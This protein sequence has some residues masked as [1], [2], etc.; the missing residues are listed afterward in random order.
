LHKIIIF[1]FSIFL[2]FNTL[3]QEQSKNNLIYSD[4]D[5]VTQWYRTIFYL[6]ESEA[7]TVSARGLAYI[8]IGFYECAAIASTIHHS[9]SGQLTDFSLPEALIKKRGENEYAAPVALNVAFCELAVELFRTARSPVLRHIVVRR[10]TLNAQFEQKI[11][12]EVFNTS[13]LIGHQI[14]DEIIK[15]AKNDGGH[16]AIIQPYDIFHKN[17]QHCDSC[18]KFNERSLKSGGPMTPKWGD[19]RLFIKENS[20]INLTPTVHFDTNKQ[21]EFYKQALEVYKAGRNNAHSLKDYTTSE[22]IADFWN[23]AASLD[24]AYTPATHSHSILLQ[25]FEK[26]L[27]LGLPDIAEIFSKL[28]IGLSDAFVV[29]WKEKFEHNLI[30]PNAYIK[31]YIDKEWLPFII[32]PEFPEFPSGHTSQIGAFETILTDFFGENYTFTDNRS[33]RGDRT[34]LSFSHAAKE[35]VE[36]RIYGGMHFRF[37][38]EQGRVLGN[39]I[40]LNVIK[41]HFKEKITK[42]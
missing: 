13:V 2:N 21:S 22:R 7:A 27:K 24:D 40:G 11:T 38:C 10:D 9:L 8:D 28:G 25:C 29:C 39:Q 23:D 31:Q 1:L 37:S 30:R 12:K 6:T 5:F 4:V 33:Y 16:E 34:F 17:I 42:Y 36:A 26:D 14:A 18:W 3:A 32:T 19:N 41:L 35:V 20:K 15:W